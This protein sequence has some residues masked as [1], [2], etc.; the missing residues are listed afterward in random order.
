MEQI[1]LDHN[2]TTPVDPKVLDAMLPF[3]RENYGNASSTTA[4]GRAARNAIEQA[5]AELASLI[6]APAE[7]ILFTSGGTESSN[8]A[9]FGFARQATA[10]RR[11]IVTSSIEHPATI[12]P[13]RALAREGFDLR[14]IPALPTGVVD[15]AAA[16]A[17]ITPE[18]ALVTIIHAQN[19]IGTIQPV[20]ELAA[21]ARAVDAPIHVDASQSLGKVPV[22]VQ[23]MS[24]D[25]LTIAGHKLYAPKGIGALYLRS[26][27]TLP[28]VMLG[29]GQ[30]YGRRPGTENVAFIAGLGVAARLAAARLE[31]ESRRLRILRD[32]L[33][34]GLSARVPGLVWVGQG[35]DML[36]NTLNVLFPGV[37]GNDLLA[38]TPEIAASTG[39][40]CHAGDSKPSA[41]L[42]ALG[43]P[44][45]MALGA[46]RLTLG[47]SSNAQ[48]IDQA[49]E[50]L[51]ERWRELVGLEQR[52]VF[53][54]GPIAVA[55]STRRGERRLEW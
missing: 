36:P 46:V 12:Q 19:E 10:A 5:R 39:S 45:A 48:E 15:L 50:I 22:N 47:R 49:A 16:Y 33:W 20:A 27:I 44:A 23:A 26:G 4:K 8:H 51:S 30:E 42:L 1:Y 31:S 25:A 14:E 2:G 21:L 55:R 28:S 7:S 53:R 17:A 54:N 35:V 9:I 37:A 52:G 11:R 18:T 13:C 24:I 40:A 29:A 6:H 43:L 32:R 34:A 41:I 3:L 38:K